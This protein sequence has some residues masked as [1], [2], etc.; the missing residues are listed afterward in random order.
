M[1]LASLSHPAPPGLSHPA[2]CDEAMH[3]LLKLYR[4]Q[5]ALEAALPCPVL[6]VVTHEINLPNSHCPHANCTLCCLCKTPALASQA[7][8]LAERAWKEVPCVVMQGVSV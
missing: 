8:G 1:S 4:E 3:A 6:L 2:V 7:R 5:K